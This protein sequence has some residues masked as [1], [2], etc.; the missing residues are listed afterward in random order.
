MALFNKNKN[1]DVSPAQ[2]L[3]TK[4]KNG[5]TNLL[6]VVGF[7]AVNLVLLIANANSYFLFSAFLPY[8][9][10]DLGMYLCGRYPAEY[11]YGDEEFLP[12]TV[13]YAAI[14][15]AV[16]MLLF[17]VLCWFMAKKGKSAWLIVALA[18]FAV[19]T[20]AFVGLGGLSADGV[21]DIIFHVWV[22]VSLA[23]G[24]VSFKKLKEL[25]EDEGTAEVPYN[26]YN[27]YGDQPY[28]P[29]NDQPY[30]PAGESDE[31]F[32]TPA[33]EANEPVAEQE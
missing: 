15:L 1:Q 19:D 27:P 2:A 16:V 31:Q 28:A 20:L 11:Y 3:E 30:A 17:Y 9:T 26:P 18:G 7:T 4:Y 13:L 22:I 6:L 25:P 32:Y 21:L 10:V 24:V 14:A 5:V 8:Y 23:S 12:E 29:V 33:D